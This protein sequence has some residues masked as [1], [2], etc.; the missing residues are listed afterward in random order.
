MLF[1]WA[2]PDE[3]AVIRIVNDTVSDIVVVAGI[4]DGDAMV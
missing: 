3:D 4:R 1:P 2:I